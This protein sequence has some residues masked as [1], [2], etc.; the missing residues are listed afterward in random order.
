MEK[1][2]TWMLIL[3]VLALHGFAS[4]VAIQSGGAPKARNM[5]AREGTE[6]SEVRRPLGKSIM[7]VSSERAA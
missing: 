6:R 3:S 7:S 2:F 5:V 4:K 1:T